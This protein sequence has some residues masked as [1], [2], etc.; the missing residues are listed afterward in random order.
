L[1]TENLKEQIVKYNTHQF[2]HQQ[3]IIIKG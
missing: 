1:C 2:V 3:S